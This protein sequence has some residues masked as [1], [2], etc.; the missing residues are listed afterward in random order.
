MQ[1]HLRAGVAVY[2]EGHHHAA[3]D[4]WEERWLDLDAGD[5]ERLLHGLIQFT[6]AVYHA[7]RGNDEG[8]T[9]L[10]ASAREY[11]ADL[12]DDLHGVDLAGVRESLRALETDPLAV[13]ENPPPLRYRGTVLRAD[14]LDVEEVGLAAEI[15]ADEEGFEAGLVADATRYAREDL[16]SG[17]TNPFVPLLFDVVGGDDQRRRVTLQRLRAHVER[18]RSREEDVSGLFD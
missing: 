16:E 12:P 13:G 18:R 7:T 11:L 4:A 10:A 9:G 8:A 17:T 14:D 2:N 15:V 6:A 3:H 5:D 1:T